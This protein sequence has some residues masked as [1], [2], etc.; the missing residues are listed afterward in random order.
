MGGLERSLAALALA[1]ALETAATGWTADA[2]AQTGKQPPAPAALPAQMLGSWGR[3]EID[4]TDFESDGRLHVTPKMLQ[5]AANRLTISRVQMQKGDWWR[6]EGLNQ[7]DG[8]KGRRRASLELRQ[9]APD[10][11][12]LRSGDQPPESFVRCRPVRLQG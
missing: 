8:R 11:L 5:F 3:E 1:L 4:C 7:E 6:V 2:R 10:R 9:P 12:L